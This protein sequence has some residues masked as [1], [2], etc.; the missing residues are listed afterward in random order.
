MHNGFIKLWRK[1][2]ETSFYKSPNT[3]HLAVHLLLDCNHEPKKFIFNGKE[4]VCDRGQTVTGLLA[5]NMA[6][7]ISIQSLRTS[8]EILENT[9]FLTSKVTNRFRVI[10][11]CKY[12]EYQDKPTSKLTISQQSTNNQLTTNNNDKNDK[13]TTKRFIKPT[14]QEIIAYCKERGN[15][16]DGQHFFNSNE[17]K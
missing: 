8:L 9:G 14:V 16:I 7:G 11:I 12:N 1:F 5:L 13:N 6:T 4:E 2:T 17:A 10:S 15:G 3:A